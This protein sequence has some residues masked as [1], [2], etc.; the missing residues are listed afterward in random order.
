MGGARMGWGI[1]VADNDKARS[2]RANLAITRLVASP[3]RV[4]KVPF[5]DGAATTVNTNYG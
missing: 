4:G 5:R 1:I 3:V 2:L